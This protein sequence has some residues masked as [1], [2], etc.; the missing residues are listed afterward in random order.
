[1]TLNSFPMWPN[2]ANNHANCTWIP[3]LDQPAFTHFYSFLHLTQALLFHNLPH[4][5]STNRGDFPITSLSCFACDCRPNSMGASSASGQIYSPL[6]F[7]WFRCLHV[8]R[9]QDLITQQ[10]ESINVLELTMKYNWNM[11]CNVSFCRFDWI[12]TCRQ[13]SIL[14]HQMDL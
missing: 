12:W 4:P 2:V 9:L 5:P 8:N 6:G 13:T 10:S 11:W 1:V 14:L 7:G 3:S